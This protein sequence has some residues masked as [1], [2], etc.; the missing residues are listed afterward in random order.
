MNDLDDWSDVLWRLDRADDA[1]AAVERFL[2][3]GADPMASLLLG[4]LHRRAG[5]PEAA[6]ALLE[7]LADAGLSR[8]VA[9]ALVEA[10]V[11]ARRGPAALE[12]CA[13]LQA[14]GLEDAETFALQGRAHLALERY[15]EARTCLEEALRRRHPRA[16]EVREL[17]DHVAAALGEG[18]RASTSTPLEPAP[19][20]AGWTEVAPL[21]PGAREAGACYL[22]RLQA[23]RYRRGAERTTTDYLRVAVLDQAQAA[24]FNAFVFEFDPL[25]EAMFVNSV[26]VLEGGEVVAT[27][28]LASQ[29]VLDDTS[30]GAPGTQKRLHVPVPGVTA[31]RTIEVV[32]TRRALRAPDEFGF[33]RRCLS[34]GYPVGLSGLEVTGD[35]AALRAVG[36]HGATVER[37]DG[38]LRCVA[39]APQ[40]YRWEPLGAHYLTYLPTVVVGDEAR[41]WEQVGRDYLAMIEAPLAPAEAA[42]ALARTTLEVVAAPGRAAALAAAVQRRLTY[43]AVAFGHRALVPR[44]VDEILGTAYGDCKDHAL[45]L[46]Q[47]LRAQGIPSALALVSVGD[48]VEAR[49]PSL[50]Q[51]DHMVVVLTGEGGDRFV[52]PTDK[53]Y[54]LGEGVPLGLGGGQAL[55]LTDPPRL[56]RVP[57]YP[58]GSSSLVVS[59]TVTPAGDVDLAVTERLRLEGFAAAWLRLELANQPEAEHLPWAQ[60][61]L[62]GLVPGARVTAATISGLK[63]VATP[64]QVDLRYTLAGALQR[65]GGRRVGR[66]PAGWETRYLQAQEHAART[67]PFAVQYPMSVQSTTRL[68]GAEVQ[69]EA[70]G[71]ESPGPF[72][73]WR[74]RVVTPADAAADEGVTVTFA[75]RRAAFASQPATRYAAFVEASR[76]ALDAVRLPFSCR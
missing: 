63:D 66:L 22:T 70:Q 65:A 33:L 5:R 68:R 71:G 4:R 43:H 46:H 61:A 2:A 9:H 25:R 69:P 57:D 60:R 42:G 16:E 44:A 55:V 35:T 6:V 37:A 12:V 13:R 26:R 49:V 19:P 54:A 20:P 75:A 45:L 50:E 11:D 52:D 3:A 36:L 34:L 7:E 73:S 39:R 76:G 24:D 31:G 62:A 32:V 38:A 14:L 74:V 41:T 53:S 59:R 56:V 23:V 30:D 67:T 72:V 48:P 27:G 10:Y 64:V 21:P 15:R 51:F 58:A 18:S 8:P 1:V 17:L 40:V 47:L 29:Y 28:D